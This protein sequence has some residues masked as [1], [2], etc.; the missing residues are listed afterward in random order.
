MYFGAGAVARREREIAQDS[1][2][3]GAGAPAAAERASAK[4]TALYDSED[5][6]IDRLQAGTLD[7]DEIEEEH[8]PESIRELDADKRLA[9]LQELLEARKMIEARIAELAKKRQEHI[10]RVMAEQQLDDSKSLDRALR[11]AIREQVTARGL[12]FPE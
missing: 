1:N 10:A 2:A 7:L 4:A 6:L 8:L 11:D 5:D 9:K 3:E 12:T